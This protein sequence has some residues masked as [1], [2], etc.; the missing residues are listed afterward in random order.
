MK[1]KRKENLRKKKRK[2]IS[3]ELEASEKKGNKE[4]NGKKK[5]KKTEMKEIRFSL[6]KGS[7]NRNKPA[8]NL[9]KVPK[10]W[11]AENA[12]TGRPKIERS[13]DHLCGTTSVSGE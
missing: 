6:L 12:Q 13:P 11:N 1:I 8:E 10:T 3:K 9:Q 4:R 7:Q 5:Q 2:R